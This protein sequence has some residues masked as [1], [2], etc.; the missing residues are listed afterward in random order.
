MEK[1]ERAQGPARKDLGLVQALL[2]H[3][4]LPGFRFPAHWMQIMKPLSFVPR[5]EGLYRWEA[6]SDPVSTPLQTQGGLF[7]RRGLGVTPELLTQ[8]VRGPFPES[9]SFAKLPRLPVQRSHTENCSA[10]PTLTCSM[11]SD[12]TV[13]LEVWPLTRVSALRETR[14]KCKFLGPTS[15]AE[16]DTWVGPGPGGCV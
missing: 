3:Q 8:Q 12:Q 9:A 15:P 6:C 13:V 4:L 16:S 7:N 11:P 1:R 14:K 5:A 2:I 10:S